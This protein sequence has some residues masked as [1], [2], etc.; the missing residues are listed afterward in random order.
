ML[1]IPGVWEAEMGRI[2]VQGQSG[3]EVRD[4]IWTNKPGMEGNT[5]VVPVMWKILGRKIIVHAG[6]GKNARPFLKD[7]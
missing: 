7:I 5:P 2:M 3:Q 6:P 4:P 1:V